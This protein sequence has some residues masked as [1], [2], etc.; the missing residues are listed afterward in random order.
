VN[1]KTTL[2]STYKC[3]QEHFVAML[4][5]DVRPILAWILKQLRPKLLTDPWD[6]L[7]NLDIEQFGAVMHG[8]IR[9]LH[10]KLL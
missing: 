2:E 1:Q 8:M 7:T 3:L 6:G 10:V 4:P 9:L 5:S